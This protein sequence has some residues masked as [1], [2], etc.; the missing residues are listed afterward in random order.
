MLIRKYGI[1]RVLLIVRV[2]RLGM[3]EGEGVKRN[4]SNYGSKM[5]YQ[6][7]SNTRP[8]SNRTAPLS[9]TFQNVALLHSHLIPA[10]E[11]D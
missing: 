8:S 7:L 9:C 4:V 11:P 2:Y 3:Q 6:E 10:I 5:C 1:Q